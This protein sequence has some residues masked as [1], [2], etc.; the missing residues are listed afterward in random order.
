[1]SET[2]K[3]Q[4]HWIAIVAPIVTALGMVWYY[5]RE[6]RI[7]DFKDQQVKS[8]KREKEANERAAKSDS[9]KNVYI[10]KYIESE[11]RFP[12][13][14]DSLIAKITKPVKDE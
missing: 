1:M 11:T 2:P 10:E 12:K 5:D 3:K 14:V 6:L 7:Q 9:I 8:E 13:L 4:I